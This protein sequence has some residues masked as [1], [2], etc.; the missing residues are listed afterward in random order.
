MTPSE[1]DAERRRRAVIHCWR[2]TKWILLTHNLLTLLGNLILFNLPLT[3]LIEVISPSSSD[4]PV[5]VGVG[6][7]IAS[8]VFFLI[9]YQAIQL[10]LGFLYYKKC[11]PWSRL[12]NVELSS[13]AELSDATPCRRCCCLCCCFWSAN[14]GDLKGCHCCCCCFV[15]LL[16]VP[17][18]IIVSIFIS[19]F[20]SVIISA[21]G[22][23]FGT[24][25]VN[26]TAQ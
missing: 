7:Y 24:E 1:D 14:H 2:R 3:L 6:M 11:H 9:I 25:N 12:L 20:S 10:G 23:Q 13:T 17:G 19:V 16:F 26:G 18:A 4:I 5:A 8:N 21:I 22:D 15:W